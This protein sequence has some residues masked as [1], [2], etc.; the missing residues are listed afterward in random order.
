MNIL[1]NHITNS[2]NKCHK[3]QENLDNQATKFNFHEIK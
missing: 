3:R 2:T 1:V